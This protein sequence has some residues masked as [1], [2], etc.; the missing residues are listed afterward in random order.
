MLN[1]NLLLGVFVSIIF[2]QNIWT[3]TSVATSDN[4][5]VFS[6]NPAGFGVSR[7][8]QSGMYIPIDKDDFSIFTADRKGNFGYSSQTKKTDRWDDLSAVGI[9]FGTKIGKNNYLGIRWNKTKAWP[10]SSSIY[11][12]GAMMRPWDFLSVGAT[13]SIDEHKDMSNLPF[14]R[15]GLALRPLSNH[16]LTIGVDYLENNITNDQTIHPFANIKFVD[17]KTN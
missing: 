13:A 12:I 9:G 2:S 3:G 11:T 4:L 16:V 8:S 7:G 14:Y 15:V 10:I 1:K 6:L 17:G 5:D